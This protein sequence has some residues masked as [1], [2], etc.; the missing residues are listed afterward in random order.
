[1]RTDIISQDQ[2]IELKNYF[3]QNDANVNTNNT[4]FFFKTGKKKN[5]IQPSA[6]NEYSFF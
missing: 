1:M 2:M 3:S 5:D 6:P 4:L